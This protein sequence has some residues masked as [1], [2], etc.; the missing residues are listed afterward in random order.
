MRIGIWF[1]VWF[2][3]QIRFRNGGQVSRRWSVSDFG[4]RIQDQGSGWRAAS[5][6]EVASGIGI[7]IEVGFRDMGGGWVLK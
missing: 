4:V 2:E 5:G 6:F 1:G 3:G 7:E